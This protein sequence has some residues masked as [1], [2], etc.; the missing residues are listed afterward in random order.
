MSAE[1]YQKIFGENV[2]HS[3]ERIAIEIG[4]LSEII[5]PTGN[6]I[7]SENRPDKV[8]G[9]LLV[10]LH[11]SL[12][13]STN[14]EGIPLVNKDISVVSVPSINPRT[15]VVRDGEKQVKHELVFYVFT[16]DYQNFPIDR[17]VD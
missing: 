8:A 17:I 6:R 14:E 16:E 12:Q 2:N 5:E 10:A 9:L 3:P 7:Y 1:N 11:K 4:D 15:S 13:P